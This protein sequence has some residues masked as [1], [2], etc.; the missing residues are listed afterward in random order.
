ML[1]SVMMILAGKL[2]PYPEVDSVNRQTFIPLVLNLAPPPDLNV[3]N[4][5][6]QFGYL[7]NGA[8]NQFFCTSR[9]EACLAVSAAVTES[10]PFRFG[11]D[12]SDGTAGTVGGVSCASGCSVAIPA[13]SQRVVYYQVLYRDASNNV[14]AQ[15]RLQM[16]ATP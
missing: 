7:E 8:A 3:D 6:V 9:R 2:P 5:L 4:A 13:L 10:N 12:G 15:T 16:A 1:G 11:S 14:V